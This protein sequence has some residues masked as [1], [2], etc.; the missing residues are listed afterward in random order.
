[1]LTLCVF[2]VPLV[3]MSAHSAVWPPFAKMMC[4]RF[5]YDRIASMMSGTD[6]AEAACRTARKWGIGHKKIP[7]E[8]LLI[9]GLSGC[10]HGHSASMASLQDDSPFK[11]GMN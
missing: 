8:E 3:N 5:Q 10:Y 1:M 9:L 4:E 6:A 7:A 11:Q 2:T